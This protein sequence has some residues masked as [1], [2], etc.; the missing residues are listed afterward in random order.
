MEPSNWIAIYVPIIVILWI[1]WWQY[2]QLVLQRILK[3]QRR[4]RKGHTAMNESLQRFIGKDCI[5]TLMSNSNVTGEVEAV[6]GNWLSLRSKK[7]A[8]PE[9]INVEFVSRIREKPRS[10]IKMA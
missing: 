8:E 6:D 3:I 1:A 7:S 9:M 2:Q 5:I 4:K 10:K